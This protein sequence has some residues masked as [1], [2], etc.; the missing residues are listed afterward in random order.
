MDNKEKA[1]LTYMLL[2]QRKLKRQQQKLKGIN[3]ANCFE[4]DRRLAATKRRNKINKK[5]YRGR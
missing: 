4:F 5:C 1:E 3:D 2:Q